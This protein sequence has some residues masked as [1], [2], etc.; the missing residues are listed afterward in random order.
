MIP[1]IAL[2]IHQRTLV[3]VLLAIGSLL[4]TQKGCVPDR[5]I[6][7]RPALSVATLTEQCD[8]G[9]DA[10]GLGIP[11]SI[12]DDTQTES[13]QT[14]HQSLKNAAVLLSRAAD[15]LDTDQLVAV[16]L[17]RQVIAILKHRVIASLIEHD[18]S[19]LPIRSPSNMTD[20]EVIDE[21]RIAPLIEIDGRRVT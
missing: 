1:D 14:P 12:K 10:T 9:M 13:L 16:Q 4:L 5:E 11:I 7:P 6:D 8:S 19:L 2:P 21:K 20:N 17:I 15:V 18:S 3:L